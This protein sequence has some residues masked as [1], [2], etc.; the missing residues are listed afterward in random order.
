[1]CSALIVIPA[2]QLV[3]SAIKDLNRVNLRPQSV[4]AHKD[5][6]KLIMYAHSALNIAIDALANQSARN[7]W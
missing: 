3:A 4:N 7:V 6:I 1:M 2:L 5:S